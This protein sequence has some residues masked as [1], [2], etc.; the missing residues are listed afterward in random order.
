MGFF[1]DAGTQRSRWNL[2]RVK[3]NNGGFVRVSPVFLGVWYPRTSRHFFFY[4]SCPPVSTR[5]PRQT[6]AKS[7][8]CV[9]LNDFQRR[10]S[11]KFCRHCKRRADDERRSIPEKVPGQVSSCEFDRSSRLVQLIA[12]PPMVSRRNSG[13]GHFFVVVKILWPKRFLI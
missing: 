6:F 10:D 2:E 4:L 13:L 12:V 11:L 8:T 7:Y 5:Q 9:V 3:W 1:G